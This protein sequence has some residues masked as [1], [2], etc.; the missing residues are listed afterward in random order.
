MNKKQLAKLL[1]AHPEIKALYESS[2]ID[3]CDISKAIAREIMEASDK[4]LM[5]STHGH[6][7]AQLRSVKTLEEIEEFIN[8]AKEE[9]EEYSEDLKAA[10]KKRNRRDINYYSEKIGEQEEILQLANK[11]TKELQIEYSKQL[12][13]ISDED[14]QKTEASLKKDEELLSITKERGAVDKDLEKTISRKKSQLETAQQKL[15][16]AKDFLK[17]Y[18]DKFGKEEPPP[19]K[20][21]VKQAPKP[22]EEPKVAA[23]PATTEPEL[24]DPAYFDGDAWENDIDAA[25]KK[26]VEAALAAKAARESEQTATPPADDPEPPDEEAKDSVKLGLTEPKRRK[27]ESALSFFLRGFGNKYK[28]LIKMGGEDKLR[29]EIG[30]YFKVAGI[31]WQDTEGEPF[32]DLSN[33]DVI[34]AIFDKQGDTYELKPELKEYV[35]RDLLTGE[36]QTFTI[37][38]DEIQQS[39][40]EIENLKDT[41]EDNMEP[42]KMSDKTPA[43]YSTIRKYTTKMYNDL[44]S[45]I[46]A[47]EEEG[48]NI[49]MDQ[50]TTNIATQMENLYQQFQ[51]ATKWSDM[52]FIVPSLA[53]VEGNEGFQ[54]WHTKNKELYRKLISN[55][56]DDIRG[57][58]TPEEL[59]A[60]L[61]DS[62]DDGIEQQMISS[63]SDYNSDISIDAEPND[64]DSGDTQVSDA[65]NAQQIRKFLELADDKYPLLFQF[66]GF[67]KNLATALAGQE[68]SPE[69]G[70]NNAFDDEDEPYSNEPDAEVP[71]DPDNNNNNF[72]DDPKQGRI[73]GNSAGQAVNEK[74]EEGLKRIF[75]MQEQT[76]EDED[77]TEEEGSALTQE[78]AEQLR[79][80]L[81]DLKD[82]M[83]KSSSGNIKA[84]NVDELLTDRLKA[85]LGLETEEETD[86]DENVEE[87]A[88]NAAQNDRKR[89][90]M[91]TQERFKEHIKTMNNFFSTKDA[92]LLG[93]TEQFLLEDQSA[94]LYGLISILKD[95][96]GVGKQR[97]YNTASDVQKNDL[98]DDQGS[99]QEQDGSFSGG[100]VEIPEE[101]R[102]S[103]KTD[104]L[105]MMKALKKLKVMITTYENN[106]SNVN[107][108]PA[109][110]G[111]SLKEALNKYLISLQTSLGKLIQRAEDA[112]IRS[113]RLK[114]NQT[115][116]EEE[117]VVDPQ[118]NSTNPNA[119]RDAELA[120]KRKAAEEAG[121]NDYTKN[122]P[123]GE[124][125]EILSEIMITEEDDRSER[126][127]R[128]D[129]IYKEM[130]QIYAPEVPAENSTGLQGQMA[131]FNE[132]KSADLAERMLKLASKEDFISL[133]PGGMIGGD[134][135]G[136]PVTVREASDAISKLISTLI[137]EMR[138][139][140]MLAKQET[141][142]RDNLIIV[143]DTLTNI[144]KSIQRFFNVPMKLSKET[145]E[146]IEKRLAE[147]DKNKSLTIQD[148]QPGS[149]APA[150]DKN[151][152]EYAG[153]APID[154][155][156]DFLKKKA[157]PKA[158]EYLK[159][160]DLYKTLMNEPISAEV[161]IDYDALEQI[162]S[163]E[164]ALGVFKSEEW[165]KNELDDKQKGAMD[166]FVKIYSSKLREKGKISEE[167][168]VVA[169]QMEELGLS[170]NAFNV[171]YTTL[172][173]ADGATP[174]APNPVAETFN[175]ICKTY[176]EETANYI[177]YSVTGKMLL[178]QDQQTPNDTGY[179]F[180][181]G[182][183]ENLN[184]K[185]KDNYLKRLFPNE[186][187]L[188]DEAITFI[189]F[190]KELADDLMAN[191]KLSQEKSPFEVFNNNEEELEENL[192]EALGDIFKSLNKKMAKVVE[193]IYDEAGTSSEGSPTKNTLSKDEFKKQMKKLSKQSHAK[194]IINLLGELKEDVFKIQQEFPTFLAALAKPGKYKIRKMSEELAYKIIRIADVESTEQNELLDECP[195]IYD[196]LNGKYGAPAAKRLYDRIESNLEKTEEETENP[197]ASIEDFTS[198]DSDS[199]TDSDSDEN[200]SE[201]QKIW[202]DDLMAL[203]N[204][205]EIKELI[206]KLEDFYVIGSSDWAYAVGSVKRNVADE[207]L[208]HAPED[209]V[210]FVNE[211]NN[212]YDISR[213]KSWNSQKKIVSATMEL[214]KDKKISLEIPDDINLDDIFDGDVAT[215]DNAEITLDLSNDEKGSSNTDNIEEALK[216]IITTMLKEQYNH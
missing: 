196:V 137:G 116:A 35:P 164:E 46:E 76:E 183:E 91:K 74:L 208:E 62:Q 191:M 16:Q 60:A 149:S 71:K 141:I 212:N 121:L 6:T 4:D 159:S 182:E 156:I 85:A 127:Q 167:Y 213:Q 21:T 95:V 214:I 206:E 99:I 203:R 138:D 178:A 165:Y 61:E 93:F 134:G 186:D 198:G 64:G 171:A 19:P 136:I 154:D 90:S 17:K 29:D 216:P 119:K 2:S 63:I 23:E 204:K 3:V 161:E 128:V 11:R 142:P 69:S 89:P 123:D 12:E 68:V 146:Q 75:L 158:L 153:R 211:L 31:D 18:E 179:E 7:M 55:K 133:F 143:V 32:K 51:N 200:S 192:G 170:Q 84:I 101:D 166:E 169:S 117:E 155:I 10:Q 73:S 26:S 1:M 125:F 122:D 15:S 180:E 202:F 148:V 185:I 108:D 176:P 8:F 160:T 120:R 110:D 100:E 130:R 5:T 47:S 210:N 80:E 50:I 162:E 105:A 131:S 72:I 150:V 40:E 193:E 25:L 13:Q 44:K 109:L 49:N 113:S 58:T 184:S 28:K 172:K 87:Q 181:H 70:V 65:M 140:I 42:E 78:Q 132:V 187:A 30:D 106:M 24:K 103:I 175:D 199:S 77:E 111:S 45:E 197:V 188:T 157:Y 54:N 112:R 163:D 86:V 115:G 114:G 43:N 98:N 209:F 205:D 152:P 194:S 48:S 57:L 168:T 52:S 9:I 82:N 174:D 66:K 173:D 56:Q 124:I 53:N 39:Q 151:A 118:P 177:Y 34:L 36:E 104:L 145:L 147:E 129:A 94:L 37:T 195:T 92:E 97:A 88:T 22:K 102:I 38:Q 135:S 215:D 201:E 190:V 83:S 27:G 126:V 79:K 81:I 139:V 67:V 41:I 20:P 207:F 33:Q 96:A 189:D 107:A 59:E 14:I 144:S